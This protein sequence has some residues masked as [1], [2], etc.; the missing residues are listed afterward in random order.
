MMALFRNSVLLMTETEALTC[1][2]GCGNPVAVT[3]ID[4]R[5][6]SGSRTMFCSTESNSPP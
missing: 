3:T 1:A 5:T 4:W 2:C 6:H